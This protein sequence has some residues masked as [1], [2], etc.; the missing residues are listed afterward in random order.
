MKKSFGL[1]ITI[2]LILIFSKLSITILEYSSLEAEKN[3]LDYLNTQASF[4]LKSLKEIL[5]KIELMDVENSYCIDSMNFDNDIF[6]IKM[7]FQYFTKNI[8]CKNIIDSSIKN[9]FAII[10][11]YIKSKPGYK[12]V[13]IH[14]RVLKKL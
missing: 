5:T 9:E 1:F 2:I 10:D 11:I 8:K 6:D 7:S 14:D 3:S 4:H 12:K 13:A